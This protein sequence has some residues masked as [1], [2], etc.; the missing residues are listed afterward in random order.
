MSAKARQWTQLSSLLLIILGILLE[1]FL[2]PESS[3]NAEVLVKSGEQIVAE[4]T[5]IRVVSICANSIFGFFFSHVVTAQLI[6]RLS[7]NMFSHGMSGVVE[8][9][10]K[11][12]DGTVVRMESNLSALDVWSKQIREGQKVKFTD[13]M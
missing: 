5:V 2:A 4:L 11:K 10:Q 3:I 6:S 13:L 7:A 8:Y 1:I 12:A 9:K